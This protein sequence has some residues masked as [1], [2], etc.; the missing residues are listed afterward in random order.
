MLHHGPLKPQRLQALC[1]SFL[2]P[3]FWLVSHWH[4]LPLLTFSTKQQTNTKNKNCKQSRRVQ[5]TETKAALT[6]QVERRLEQ[7]RQYSTHLT[8][9]VSLVVIIEL[10]VNTFPINKTNHGVELRFSNLFA[11]K[12]RKTRESVNLVTGQQQ[13]FRIIILNDLKSRYF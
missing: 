7:L 10:S 1:F 2:T 5:N 12:S 11:F 3:D 13:N 8:G 9:L 4:E 6:R